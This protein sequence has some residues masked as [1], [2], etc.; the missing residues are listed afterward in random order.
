MKRCLLPTHEKHVQS[1]IKAYHNVPKYKH[2][3]HINSYYKWCLHFGT[4]WYQV[5]ACLLHTEQ[6]NKKKTQ[7]P[8]LK[9]QFD[10]YARRY[11][12]TKYVLYLAYCSGSK[13]SHL[14][15]SALSS[16]SRWLSR[17]AV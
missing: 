11:L 3:F 12:P 7:N 2:H 14:A 1:I 15:T 5:C 8:K 9:T 10:Q 6:T 17:L 13:F 4:E 16:F